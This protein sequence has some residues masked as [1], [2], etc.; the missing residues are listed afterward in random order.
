MCKFHRIQA[1]RRHLA[2]HVHKDGILR[3]SVVSFIQFMPSVSW[4]FACYCTHKL[5]THSDK[6]N[7]INSRH[8]TVNKCSPNSTGLKI[9]VFCECCHGVLYY[10]S[11]TSSTES[12]CLIVHSHIFL[13]LSVWSFD[14]DKTNGICSHLITY[15][16][17]KS[18]AN[19]ILIL[20][21]ASPFNWP[22]IDVYYFGHSEEISQLLL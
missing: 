12:T 17:H 1:W 8:L 20:W 4:L 6:T 16:S 11:D 18:Y 19:I 5:Y 21:S 7:Y 15:L 22:F 3:I 9:P 14:N 13:P 2:G 10:C